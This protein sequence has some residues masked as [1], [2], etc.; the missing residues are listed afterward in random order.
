MA[1]VHILVSLA[2]RFKDEEL[3]ALLDEDDCQTQE[4]LA[5]YFGVTHTTKRLKT[6]GYTLKHENWLSSEL[7][8]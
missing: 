7:K 3:E 5:K 4:D 8:H 2:K 1:F 6:A